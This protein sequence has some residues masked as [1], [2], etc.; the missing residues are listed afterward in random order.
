MASMPAMMRSLNSCFELT[1]MWRK[2][3]R[4]N[5]EKRLD[6]V[7]PR[8]VFWHGGKFEAPWPSCVEPCSGLS[9]DVRRMIVEPQLDRSAGRIGGIEKLEEVDKLAAAGAVPDERTGLPG[10]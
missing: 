9:R 7:E 4:A 8:G 10:E 2:T 6:E 3:D 5:L 1:R